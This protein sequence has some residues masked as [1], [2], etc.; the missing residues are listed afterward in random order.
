MKHGIKKVKFTKGQ[1]SHQALV[2]KLC[3]NFLK[4][5]HIDTTTKRA[6]FLKARI[7]RMMHKAQKATNADR[8]V[9]LKELADVKVVEHLITVIAPKF[10]RATGFVSL[11]KLMIR[12]GDSSDMSRL[13]WVDET[14]VSKKASQD[15][16]AKSEKP[17]V[18]AKKTLVKKVTETK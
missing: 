10:K 4:H 2:R 13:V 18:K 5:G 6:K 12:Q 9:L 3:L 8:N 17:A 1:D 14:S 11:S 15:V 7:D 16:E